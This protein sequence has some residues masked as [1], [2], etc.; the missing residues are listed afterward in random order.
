M[1]KVGRNDP[2]PCGSG[3]KYKRCC[4]ERVEAEQRA[5]R[6]RAAHE[7]AQRSEAVT[8]AVG[9]LVE[10]SRALEEAD[11]L[12]EESEQLI[13]DGWLDEAEVVAQRLRA[14][15]VEDP[16]G[17]E[18]QG[19]VHEAR[20]LLREAADEYR[21]GVALMDELGEGHYCDCC[22]ARMVKAIGRLDPEGPVPALMVDPQ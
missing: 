10:E 18:R 21:R 9:R 12:A 14:E 1:W 5:E 16:V 22:R 4:I 8:E 17:F 19:Q 11:R 13:K 6:A 3:K 2:C 15:F 7:Q 20:G